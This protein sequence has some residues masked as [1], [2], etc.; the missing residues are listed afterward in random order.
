L[1]SEK[2]EPSHDLESNPTHCREG[3][4]EEQKGM[5]QKKKKKTGGFLF[6]FLGGSRPFSREMEKGYLKEAE[7][8]PSSDVSEKTAQ[9]RTSGK[10]GGNPHSLAATGGLEAKN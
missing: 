2:A 6:F 5:R 4:G 3:S 9:A 10:T 8:L 1:P 7:S